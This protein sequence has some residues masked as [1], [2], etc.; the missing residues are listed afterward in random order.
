MGPQS[1]SSPPCPVFARLRLALFLLLAVRA[2]SQTIPA[3]PLILPSA[4]VFD[5]QGNLYL[6]ETANHVIRK[7]APNGVLTVIAGTATQG[8]SGD[9]GFA[10]AAQLDS[11]QGLALDANQNLYIADTHNHRI[12]RLNLSTGILTTISGSTPGFSGDA[13]L[14]SAAHLNLPTAL[15]FDVNQNLYIADSGNHRIRRIDITTGLITTIA[16]NGTQGFSG[17]SGLAV[18]AA[19]DSPQGL[20]VDVSQNL[21]LSDTHNHRI[22]KVTAATGLI[23]TIAGNGVPGPLTL[24]HGISLDSSGNV[25]IADTSNH[26]IRRIDATTGLIAVLAGN[27]VQG[28]AGD[29]GPALSA[30]LDSPTAVS[31]SPAGLLTFS[32]AHNGHIRQVSADNTIQTVAA[33]GSSIPPP[34]QTPTDFTLTTT[35]IASQTLLTGGTASYAFATQTQGTLNSAI[36]LS[37]SGLPPNTVATFSPTYLPPGPVSNTFTLTLTTLKAAATLS[38]RCSDPCAAFEA[39]LLPLLWVRGSRRHRS[40]AL[41]SLLIVA[42]TGCGARVNSGNSQSSAPPKIYTVTV[43]GTATSPAGAVLTHSATVTVTLQ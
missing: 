23:T 20:A 3:A 35:G 15:A 16:G 41:L 13:G 42:I 37:A 24:P 12:R 6:A 32:D 5:A 25:Y 17:D 10:T 36:T 26:R 38:S 8:F 14:A 34:V 22:R 33:L 43:T 1:I 27:G 4:I 28:S 2:T 18:T 7:L 40:I 31:V 39:L 19:I 11:P 30:S 21:Y 29:S 9:N